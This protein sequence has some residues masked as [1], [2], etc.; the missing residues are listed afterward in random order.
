MEDL[1]LA[2]PTSTDATPFSM[3][4]VSIPPF[5]T[6]LMAVPACM[7]H[8]QVRPKVLAAPN[9]FEKW[10]VCCPQAHGCA[11]FQHALS[12]FCFF[13]CPKL[14]GPA[15]TMP[16][17]G[18]KCWRLQKHP[19]HQM[20][21][22]DLRTSA[23]ICHAACQHSALLRN[24]H[25][26]TSLQQFQSQSQCNK[27]NRWNTGRSAIPYF[28]TPRSARRHHLHLTLKIQLAET[29]NQHGRNAIQ[30]TASLVHAQEL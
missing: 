13:T 2:A 26:C 16:K 30:P 4:P 12:A 20:S 9:G 23:T 22:P 8:A 18:P 1:R 17:S 29:N 21:C 14:W 24:P 10:R 11:A 7:H 3:R 15:C 27:Q 28:A 5:L 25:C 6:R 19:N